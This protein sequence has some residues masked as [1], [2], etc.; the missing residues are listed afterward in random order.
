MKSDEMADIRLFTSFFE[1]DA[2][3]RITTSRGIHSSSRGT[4]SLRL[5]HPEGIDPSR[6]LYLVLRDG[7]HFRTTTFRRSQPFTSSP[8]FPNT[9]YR[10]SCRGLVLVC[11]PSCPP[12][13]SCIIIMYG[14][15][16][17]CF[18]NFHSSL[19][20]PVRHIWFFLIK[21]YYI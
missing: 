3:F 9:S 16:L 8:Q 18:I 10:V 15:L 6:G 14:C 20:L 17:F 11:P 21:L 5:Q 19:T 1:T 7:S 4:H 13:S 12:A 2:P